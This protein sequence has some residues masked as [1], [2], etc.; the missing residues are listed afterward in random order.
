MLTGA[1]FGLLTAIIWGVGDFLSRKPSAQIGSLL[2]S[3]YV[4]P[5]GL[6]L[7]LAFSLVSGVGNFSSVLAANQSYLLLNLLAGVLGFVGLVLLYRGYFTGVMSVVAPIAGSYPA[8]S[9]TLSVVLL[10]TVLSPV[11]SIGIVGVI[12]GIILTGVRLSDFRKAVP[13]SENVESSIQSRSKIIQGV[14]YSI[15]TLV[16]AGIALFTLGVVSPVI[17]PI[18]SVLVFKC[19]ETAAALA[20]IIFAVKKVVRPSKSTLR[21]LAIIGISDAGGFV[22]FNYGVQVSGDIPIVVTLSGLIGVIT[23][24]MARV[25]YRERLDKVQTLGVFV[26]FVSVAA[27]LYFQ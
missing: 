5:I 14:D 6:A 11:K 20:L 8:V 4:Q 9:V 2:T 7:L 26:I 13:R 12:L 1:I 16:C 25:F 23:V 15:A 24:I 27:I 3:C 18:F 21:W 10:G 19:A 17:G 22:T